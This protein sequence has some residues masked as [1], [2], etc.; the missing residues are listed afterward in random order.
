MRGLTTKVF[1]KRYAMDYLPA[2]A[3][4]RRKRGLSVPLSAWLRGPLRD[5]AHA[6]LS[7]P[8]LG[9][10]GIDI[11]VAQELLSKHQ[12]RR[13]DHARA[14]WTLVVLSEWLDWLSRQEAWRPRASAPA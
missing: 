1:L 10:A 3:V 9:Q 13:G 7:S 5:W 12:A 4:R 14:V 11:R 2:S 6:R 8:A